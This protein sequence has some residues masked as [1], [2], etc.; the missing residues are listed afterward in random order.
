MDTFEPV[1]VQ[2]TK[3]LEVVWMM[4]SDGQLCIDVSTL[5]SA[6]EK[7]TRVGGKNTTSVLSEDD[8]KEKLKKLGI[9][10]GAID[11]EAFVKFF[12]TE[13]KSGVG[14]CFEDIAVSK[15]LLYSLRHK[16]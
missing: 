4:L 2:E 15:C 6:N 11:F 10:E 3:G 1:S 9:S 13:K 5:S 12:S 8:V 16:P 14:I 7:M